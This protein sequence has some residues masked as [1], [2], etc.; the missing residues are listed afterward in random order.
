MRFDLVLKSLKKDFLFFPSC[1]EQQQVPEQSLKY[2]LSKQTSK[3]HLDL[4]SAEEPP[5]Q[6][7]FL[8]AVPSLIFHS[9][10]STQKYWNDSLVI[11]AVNRLGSL[12]EVSKFVLLLELFPSQSLPLVLF[13]ESYLSDWRS[14]LVSHLH[15]VE[16]ND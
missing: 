6:Q 12:V 16:R 9:Q 8:F 14:C 3:R 2:W 10:D 11:I 1:L 7:H 15:L 5:S 13:A 4:V